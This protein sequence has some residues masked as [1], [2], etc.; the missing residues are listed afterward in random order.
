[1]YEETKIKFDWKGFLLKF[2]ILILLLILIIKLLPFENKRVQSESF[3]ENINKLK[4]AAAD[5]FKT[6]K[7]PS[8]NG[9]E[10]TITLEELIVNG[11]INQLKD[12]KN[13]DCDNENSY[14]KATNNN[15]EYEIDA[16]LI[17]NKEEGH[18]YIYRTKCEE[19]KCSQEVTTTKKTNKTTS[20]NN[21]NSSSN[22]SN[23]NK[24][25]TTTKITY[26]TEIRTKEP[27]YYVVF[28]TNYGSSIPTQVLKTNQTA[29]RPSNPTREGYEFINW[30]HNGKEFDF[31]TPINNNIVLTAKW[32]KK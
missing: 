32:Q 20:K 1:M 31:N 24:V 10:K 5:Y 19:Q 7:L 15:G 28:D 25:N 29:T 9:D 3:K 21:N 16:F 8:K 18:V 6:D 11:K 2:A 27:K 30:M 22:N 23:S 12:Q 4:I 26:V 14:I 17:C 13:G